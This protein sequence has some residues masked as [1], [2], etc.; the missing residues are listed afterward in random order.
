MIGFALSFV[1]SS[2]LSVNSGGFDGLVI[3]T[4]D[5]DEF[6]FSSGVLAASICGN[7]YV[8]AGEDCDDGNILNGD[9]CS[10]SCQD[11]EDD[12][13]ED[14]GGGGG[15]G[16][17]DQ[18]EDENYIVRTIFDL[19]A[20]PESLNLPATVGIETEAKLV[21][22]NNGDK[23]LFLIWEVVALDDII[24]FDEVSFVLAPGESKTLDFFIMPDQSGVHSGK[25]VF[26][27]DAGIYEV[28]VVLNINSRLTL[29]DVIL[30]IPNK[31]RTVYV[32]EKVVGNISL[33][34]MGLVSDVDV[35]VNY[36]IKDFSGKTYLTQTETIKVNKEKFYSHVYESGELPPGDYIAGV[37]VVYA[38]G[39][40]TA[41]AQFRVEARGYNFWWILIIL[42]LLIL[43]IIIIFALVRFF[44][45]FRER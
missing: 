42:L 21:L 36:V 18:G 4:N 27:G 1:S 20:I 8:E 45:S 37:E 7:G 33:I 26:S 14:E 31:M 40:A 22:V 10:A 12:Q 11:E 43:I 35:A 38:G 9:G 16:G 24:S 5:V 32:G 13:G 23:E 19:I 39:I 15:G 28:P 3:N 44:A 6:F 17:G 41:S 34:Q 2:V 25:F 29:F 30:T